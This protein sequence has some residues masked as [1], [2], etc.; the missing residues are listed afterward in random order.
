MNCLR[1][2]LHIFAIIGTRYRNTISIKTETYTPD[3]DKF[4]LLYEY[5]I[6]STSKGCRS[7][8]DTSSGSPIPNTIY[9]FAVSLTFNNVRRSINC[10]EGVYCFF[11]DNL[12]GSLVKEIIK[13]GRK[14]MQGALLK[15]EERKVSTFRNR[16]LKETP[17]GVQNVRDDI[18]NGERSKLT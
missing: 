13:C 14:W 10:P 8:A 15:T 5:K 16:R 4:L 18:F 2:L 9:G 6:K 11:S 3:C 12:L 17:R 1:L 7:I